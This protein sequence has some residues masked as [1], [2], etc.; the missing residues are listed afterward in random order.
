MR[1][2]NGA[3]MT[4]LEIPPITGVVQLRLK[5]AEDNNHDYQAVLMN[6]RAL[7]I[8]RKD[9]LKAEVVNSNK[10]VILEIPSN[11]L[12]HGDYQIKLS[13]HTSDSELDDMGRYYFRVLK[14]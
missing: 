6:D 14:N 3:Q 5:V 11:I 1:N 8:F 4:R 12:A 9:R 7:E 13:R 10:V 2:D